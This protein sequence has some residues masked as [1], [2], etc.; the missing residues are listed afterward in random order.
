MTLYPALKGK[1]FAQWQGNKGLVCIHMGSMAPSDLLPDCAVLSKLL[2]SALQKAD[3]K[4]V[5]LTVVV[6]T[7]SKFCCKYC[8][9]AFLLTYLSHALLSITI[10]IGALVG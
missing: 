9:D 10:L 4:G 1:P 7:N 6:S 5:L 2:T 8:S 3:V